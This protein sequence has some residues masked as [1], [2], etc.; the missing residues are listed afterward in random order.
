MKPKILVVR[1]APTGVEHGGDEVVYRNTYKVLDKYFDFPEFHLVRV[2]R[3]TQLVETLRGA[4]AEVARYISRD[5]ERRLAALLRQNHFDLVCFFNE[6]SFSYST[7]VRAAGLP[8]VLIAH[9]AHSL[10]AETDPSLLG[11][12][13]RP[14]AIKFERQHYTDPEAALV[15]IAECDREALKKIGIDRKDVYLSPPGSPPPSPLAID[16]AILPEVVLTGSYAWWRK[17]RDLKAFIQQG[18]A[19]F[20]LW[21]TDEAAL[22]CLASSNLDVRPAAPDW[23]QIRFGLIADRFSGGFKLKSTEYVARNCI[24]LS[25]AD[26]RL[27]FA[28]L[29]HAVEFVRY[30]TGGRDEVAQ[31]LEQYTASE[32]IVDRF[33]VFR[34]ACLERFEWNRCLE[35]LRAAIVSKL[36]D[37]AQ[38]EVLSV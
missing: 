16:A 12:L 21:A 37:R 29:P 17:R 35:P 31:I 36:S 23:S 19:V 22:D 1:P 13:I 7:V 6:A 4:P 8:R 25:C 26:I 32:G 34:E 28:G 18:A 38:V 24:I 27:E 10:V 15:C 33:R 30:I 20:P 11:K 3:L 2:G 14:L 9:N 5:S